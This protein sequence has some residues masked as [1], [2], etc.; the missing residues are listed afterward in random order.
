LSDCGHIVETG[1]MDAWVSQRSKTNK[2]QPIECPKCMA[3]VREH[4]RYSNYIKIQLQAI[5][6]IKFKEALNVKRMSRSVKQL[7][8]EIKSIKRGLVFQPKLVKAILAEL[9][10]I[11]ENLDYIFMFHNIWS[12]YKQLDRLNRLMISK[13][14]DAEQI[15]HLSYEIDQL[16]SAI[17]DSHKG[18][19][20]I[21]S[22]EM[23]MIDLSNGIERVKALFVYYLFK[24]ESKFNL[25]LVKLEN[26]NEI[27]EL[28]IDEAHRYEGEVRRRVE[29]AIA[30]LSKSSPAF[31]DVNLPAEVVIERSFD[32]RKSSWTKCS[33]GHV[34]PS[35]QQ[36]QHFKC[37]DCQMKTRTTGVSNTQNRP[38]VHF[39]YKPRRFNN[40]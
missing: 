5:E 10:Y 39:N 31:A 4:P 19:V 14:K 36:Q 32:V 21:V 28:L 26:L 3:P 18:Q 2:I 23:N 6:R 34:Y 16:V 20:N 27:K 33:K 12:V 40:F 8:F 9:E 37:P 15:E 35:Q 1:K 17:F 25:D 30:S 7:Y 22:T 24:K 11:E 29:R 13:L 38:P